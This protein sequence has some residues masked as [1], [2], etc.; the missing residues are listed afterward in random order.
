MQIFTYLI[1]LR[2]F[3]S[4]FL[5]N[6]NMVELWN[7]IEGNFLEGICSRLGH[8]MIQFRKHPFLLHFFQDSE[9]VLI[10]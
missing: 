2:G 4:N 1:E 9:I 8:I 10:F 7:E 3:T 6:S 5:Q